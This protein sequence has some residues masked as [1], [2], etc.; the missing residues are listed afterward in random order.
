MNEQKT[1]HKGLFDYSD[2]DG[3]RGQ[4]EPPDEIEIISDNDIQQNTMIN[5]HQQRRQHQHYKSLTRNQRKNRKK[6]AKRYRFEIIR[7]VY[8]K[9]TITKH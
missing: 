4:D 6:R 5:Q 9:F 2:D 8:Y 3:V 1:H 7:P